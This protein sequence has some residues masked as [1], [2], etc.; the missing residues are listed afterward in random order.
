MAI[1]IQK[2]KTIWT[3][4][5]RENPGSTLRNGVPEM[6]PIKPNDLSDSVLLQEI[7]FNEGRFDKPDKNKISE[8]NEIQFREH[9][10]DFNQSD[11]GL[12]IGFW[13]KKQI[14]KKVGI[15]NFNSWCQIKT[16]K[17]FPIE[18]T[19]GY[20]KIVYNVFYG[21]LDGSRDI[22]QTEKIIEKDYQTLLK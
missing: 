1:Y 8:I 18:Y 10:L 5:S 19:W 17:R 21:Q 3:K 11:I 7:I 6:L 16:N 12:E 14:R 22:F 15:L 4:S 13:N 2:I 20:Y 9:N